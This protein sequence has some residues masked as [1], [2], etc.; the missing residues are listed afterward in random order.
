MEILTQLIKYIAC[1]VLMATTIK[2]IS[3]ILDELWFIKEDY[4]PNQNLPLVPP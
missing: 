1:A 4:M 2:L 3:Y